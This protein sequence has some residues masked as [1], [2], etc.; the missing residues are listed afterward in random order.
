MEI[1]FVMHELHDVSL[2]ECINPAKELDFFIA[3][4][5]KKIFPEF[6]DTLLCKNPFC[7]I[8]NIISTSEKIYN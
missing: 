8:L 3:Y 1:G 5:M 4:V 6:N 2:A 7:H